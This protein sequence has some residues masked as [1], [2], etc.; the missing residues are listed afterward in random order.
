MQE[1]L[2]IFSW[3]ITEIP[4]NDLVYEMLGVLNILYSSSPQVHHHFLLSQFCGRSLS[5][6]PDEQEDLWSRAGMAQR[7]QWAHPA[8][9]HGL[10]P[11]RPQERPEPRSQGDARRGRAAGS[12]SWHP[13]CGNISQMQQ[14][15][16]T[17]FRAAHTGHLWADEDGWDLHSWRLGWGQ[18]RPHCQSSLSSWGGS[19]A[20]KELQLL[21]STIHL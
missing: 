21:T 7:S 11:D 19:G 18:E 16:G 4:E 20:R 17:C 10:H 9:S 5:F 15:R 13:L 14:Q 2:S 6:W 12:R 8:S 3:I 1:N